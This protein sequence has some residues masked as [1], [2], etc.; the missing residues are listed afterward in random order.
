MLLSEHGLGGKTF[1]DEQCIR[2]PMIFY[3]PFTE[4]E[5]GKVLGELVAGQDV[6]AT[7]LDLCGLSIPDAHQGQSM[8]PLI[9]GR[10]IRWR[11]EV[12]CENLFTDQGYPRMEAVRGTEWKYIRYFS[13]QN[14]RRKYL[15]DASISG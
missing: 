1:L 6:P 12:F 8:V 5:R 2:I 11:Q 10:P 4:E 3:S 7:I 9:E 13:K 14:D 15:P